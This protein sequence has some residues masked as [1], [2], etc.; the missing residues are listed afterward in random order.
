MTGDMTVEELRA[1]V[2]PGG[3][4]EFTHAGGTVEVPVSPPGFEAR[5]TGI[6]YNACQYNRPALLQAVCGDGVTDGFLGEECDQGTANSNVI[7]NRCR[8]NCRLA[9]LG[10]GVL[11]RLVGRLARSVPPR[12][13]D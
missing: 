12:T 10:D 1:A 11:D 8:R 3:H 2:G 7:A 13:R 4:L 6:I 9:Y 5:V